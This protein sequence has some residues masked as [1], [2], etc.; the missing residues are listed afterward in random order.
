MKAKR[1]FRWYTVVN[2]GTA[3]VRVAGQPKRAD[4]IGAGSFLINPGEELLFT[5]VTIPADVEVVR[6]GW[7]RVEV[8]AA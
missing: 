2:V 7:S 8:K 1:I 4:E 5:Q 6:H 3:P